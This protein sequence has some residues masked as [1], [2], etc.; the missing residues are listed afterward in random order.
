MVTDGVP[1]DVDAIARLMEDNP[2]LA[3]SLVTI[4][5][6]KHSLPA[7]VPQQWWEEELA[8]LDPLASLPNV[9][10]VALGRGTNGSAPVD[11]GDGRRAQLAAKLI[12]PLVRSHP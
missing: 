7:D 11:V 12:S 9:R 2:R 3:Q 1:T 6:S 10:I 4:G 5:R 8:A